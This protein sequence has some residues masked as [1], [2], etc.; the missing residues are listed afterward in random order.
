MIRLFRKNTTSL[1]TIKL[2][3][4]GATFDMSDAA[5]QAHVNA[6]YFGWVVMMIEQGNEIRTFEGI[7][8]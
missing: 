1:L 5:I 6:M 7:F 2:S 3:D 4:V 8:E